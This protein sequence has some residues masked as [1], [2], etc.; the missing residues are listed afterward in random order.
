MGRQLTNAASRT[1]DDTGLAGLRRGLGQAGPRFPPTAPS[2]WRYAGPSAGPR[3]S[4]CRY[5]RT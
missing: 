3:S 2:G 4:G 1:E 5:H